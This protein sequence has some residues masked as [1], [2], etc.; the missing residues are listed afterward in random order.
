[1]AASDVNDADEPEDLVLL[2]RVD[3]EFV[4]FFVE[5]WEALEE[6]VARGDAFKSRGDEGGGLDGG[7]GLERGESRRRCGGRGRDQA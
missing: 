5:F 1:L 3:A 4:E 7:E 2:A 6:L